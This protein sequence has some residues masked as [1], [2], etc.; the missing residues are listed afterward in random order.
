MRPVIVGAGPVGSHT[1]KL[2]SELNPL[3]IDSKKV[4]GRPVQCTG[5]ISLKVRKETPYPDR[6]ID[7]KIKGV[8]LKS[9]SN[10]VVLK[11]RR[12][13]AHVIDR[14]AYDEWVLSNYDGELRLGEQF[15]GFS[16]GVVKTSKGEYKTDLLIDCSG[17]SNRTNN[18]LGVQSIVKLGMID[19]LVEVNFNASPDFFGWVVPEGNGYCRVGLASSVSNNPAGLLR[20]YLRSL[21]SSKTKIDNAGLIP[22]S[23]GEFFNDNLVR[24]GDAAGFV[25]AL[26]GGGILMGLLSSKIMSRAVIRSFERDDFSR[27]FFKREYY[28][29]WVRTVGRELWFHHKVR[30][31]LN[32]L[33]VKGYDELIKF[34]S[35][36]KT[37]FEDYGDIDF[38][39]KTF[40]KLLKP[41]NAL[42]LIK[43]LIKFFLAQV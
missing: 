43:S 18:L 29:P 2:I 3:L 13:M 10:Q 36:N 14:Q 34:I 42:F 5:L 6:V 33:G 37:V 32:S 19:D 38:I 24:C 11:S 27:G 16:N 15:K 41:S 26:S 23:V 4:I 21:G 40:I 12:V 7:N 1:A 22:L 17:P 31:Y 35:N 28:N 8:I 9:R 39:S 20:S 30:R 25:K